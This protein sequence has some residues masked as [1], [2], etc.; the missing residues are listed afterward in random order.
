ML[1][2]KLALIYFLSYFIFFSVSL[3]AQQTGSIRGIVVDSLSG[4][5]LPYANALIEGLRTGAAADLRGIFTITGIPPNR[6]YNLR[7]TF[8]GYQNKNIKVYVRANSIT[9]VKIELAPSSIQLGVIEKIGQKENIKNETDISVQKLTAKQIELIPKGVET[10]IF[11]SL[12]FLPGVQSTGD[13]S[14]RYY[15]RGSPSNQN[16]VLLNGVTVYNPFH[17]LGLFSIIDPEMINAVEF[18]KGGF[19]AEYGDRLSSVLNLI[20][21]DGNRNRYGGN[22]SLSFLT[23]K[24]A[25]EGPIPGGSFIVTGRQSLFDQVLKKFTN[26]KDA[27]FNFH[28]LSAKV[29]LQS[30]DTKSLTKVSL[31]GFNSE[32]K[33]LNDDPSKADY[34]WSNNLLSGYW[35]QAWENVPI[36]SETSLSLSSFNGQIIPNQSDAKERNN[37]LTDVTLKTDFTNIYDSRDE[38][39]VGYEIKSVKT[40]LKFQNLEGLYSEFYDSGL[41]FSLYGKYRFL[42]FE[43]FGVDIGTRVNLLSLSVN[44]A[45]FFEPRVSASYT[46]LP[47]IKLKAAYGIYSQELI[48]ITNE[49][50]IISLFEPWLILPDYLQVPEAFHY[51]AGIEF[52]RIENLVFNV[53]LYYKKMKN[54]AEINDNKVTANDPDFIEGSGESYGSEF[55]LQYSRPFMMATA[56]YSLSWAYRNINGWISYPRYDIR[57]SVNL[58]LTYL[59]GSGWEASASWFFNSGL[60]FTQTEGYYDKFYFDNLYNIGPL[61]GYYKPFTI[62]AD[63]NLGRLPTYHRLDLSLTKNFDIS[64]AKASL[65]LNVLNV[66]NRKNIFYF[67]RDTGRI[68]NMLPFLPSATFKIEL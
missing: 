27:P 21:K 57:H 55:S 30:E 7:I 65:S 24:G 56:S 5:A 37:S 32:D 31:L 50:E 9:Q 39:K 48:T 68:V 44:H 10:D 63:P 29:N 40:S 61:F 12:R 1:K 25:V 38:I 14:A 33:L 34:K 15:V 19:P 23:A 58:S 47:G 18:Y 62:L 4:E 36:Y 49:N 22:A 26:Y 45:P 66:Y 42:R 43:N 16:L 46:F 59:F 11:R 60:P 2:K 51:I 64:F 28:D 54:I 8:L 35:F 17:A 67:E 41:H 20:T 13:V 6:N 3:I 52:R 53:E